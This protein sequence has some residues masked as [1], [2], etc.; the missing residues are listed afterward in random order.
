M[1]VL[2]LSYLFVLF[3]ILPGIFGQYC[4]HCQGF[5]TTTSNGS[6]LCKCDA[7]C[8][9]F[10]DCCGDYSPT[11]SSSV[12][13]LPSFLQTGVKSECLSTHVRSVDLFILVSSESEAFLMISS[14]PDSWVN[15][16]IKNSCT[17]PRLNYSVP[18][19]TDIIT[20]LVYKNEYSLPCSS[21]V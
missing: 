10:G 5:N 3:A 13:V 2:T 7:H 18:P 6:A 4:N 1:G 14:C 12:H 16:V 17:N 9:V 21:L 11:N 19:V 8:Q 20:G 15:P